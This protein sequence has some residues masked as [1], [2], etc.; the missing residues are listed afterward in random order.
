LKLENAR[1]KVEMILKNV[2][3]EEANKKPHTPMS[4]FDL[5]FEALIIVV[6]KVSSRDIQD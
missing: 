6:S 3:M 4:E 5:D 1:I 2:R